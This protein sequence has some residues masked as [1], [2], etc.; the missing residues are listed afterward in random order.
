VNGKPINLSTVTAADVKEPAERL[1]VNADRL[2]NALRASMPSTP[3]PPPA[4]HDIV[5][6]LARNLGTSEDKVRA[7]LKEVEG[8]G[9]FYF[10]VPLLGR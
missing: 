9:P 5:G 8:N 7:A 1:G 3:P 6:G 2:A 10:V 4:E